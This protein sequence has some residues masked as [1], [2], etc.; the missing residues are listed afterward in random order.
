[1]RFGYEEW[2]FLWEKDS[3]GYFFKKKTG[4]RG[5][6]S[7]LGVYLTDALDGLEPANKKF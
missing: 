6:S 2:V 3:L 5:A 4:E 1:M 7:F